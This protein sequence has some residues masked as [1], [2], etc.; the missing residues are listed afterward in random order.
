LLPVLCP[1]LPA[2]VCTILGGVGG[3]STP[4]TLPTGIST[5]TPTSVTTADA[6][7]PVEL[8]VTDPRAAI[9]NAAG[10]VTVSLVGPTGSASSQTFA[11]TVNNVAG[12]TVDATFN[13]STD[14]LPPAPGSYLV[15]V[16]VAS[17]S[18]LSSL[19]SGLDL[20]SLPVDLDTAMLTVGSTA[21]QPDG[22]LSVPSGGSAPASISTVLNLPFV[23]GD[24]VSFT[25]SKNTPVTGLSLSNLS[26]AVNSITGTLTAASDV[27]AG[28][29]NLVVSDLLGNLGICTG[30][31]T[32]TKDTATSLVVQ[33]GKTLLSAGKTTTLTGTLTKAGAPLA[34][35]AVYIIDK[36]PTSK[37]KLLGLTHTSAT[38][39]FSYLVTPAENTV[40]AVWF[41]G[42]STSLGKEL[43]SL[44]NIV[45]LSVAPKL[46][47][48]VKTAKVAHHKHGARMVFA[49]KVAPAEP[50]AVVTL[51]NKGKRFGT[52]KVAKNGTFKLTKKLVKRGH[53]SLVAKIA[54]HPAFAAAAS[55]TV[56][57]SVS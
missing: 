25:D 6:E 23:L 40:Y 53:Y 56:H 34:D 27:P 16:G 26:L 17:S 48:A 29:Y 44:S 13:L 19:L 33:L 32:V 51:F 20:T 12:T 39:A 37:A 14:N 42:D 2:S 50:G 10:G 8:Q 18:A 4:L 3:G 36:D 49:G 31:V 45:G 1:P 5:I 54:S 30:C 35:H 55:K 9:Y 52:A 7:N 57:K 21:P 47:M 43:A 15:T 22:L 46:T 11:G 28:H 24:L 38:G 41:I